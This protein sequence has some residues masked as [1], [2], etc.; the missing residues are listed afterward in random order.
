MIE[1]LVK[2]LENNGYIVKEVETI[3][4]FIDKNTTVNNISVFSKTFYKEGKGFS[5]N[6][7]P[8]IKEK[9][10]VEVDKITSTIGIEFYLNPSQIKDKTLIYE[11]KLLM[12]KVA[13]DIIDLLGMTCTKQEYMFKYY[14]PTALLYTSKNYR[15]YYIFL[16][17]LE[18]NK[19]IRFS[20]SITK[21]KFV[22]RYL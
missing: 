1:K 19:S 8:K 7:E 16:T 20:L 18:N 6:Y 10:K 14:Y 9:P 22:I 13:N 17:N 3:I 2:K 15:N 5:K 21:E 11:T 4:N 12:K